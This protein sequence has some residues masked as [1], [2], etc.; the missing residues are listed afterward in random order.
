MLKARPSFDWTMSP[1]IE[2]SQDDRRKTAPETESQ[3]EETA[4]NSKERESKLVNW[5]GRVRITC[6]KGK[7]ST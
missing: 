3:G 5:N 6:E 4:V 2:P 1:M 7:K